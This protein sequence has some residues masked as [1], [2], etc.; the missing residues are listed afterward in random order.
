MNEK[1]DSNAIVD[2]GLVLERNKPFS[3]EIILKADSILYKKYVKRVY[4]HLFYFS[5]VLPSVIYFSM[6]YI[7]DKQ[8]YVSMISIFCF[9][10]IFA[11]LGLI[12]GYYIRKLIISSRLNKITNNKIYVNLSFYNDGLIYESDGVS[13][14]KHYRELKKIDVI[15]N[16]I[17]FYLT[18]RIT[19]SVCKD[20]LD[21]YQ[22]SF[23]DL[24]LDKLND[25]DIL[26]SKK[27]KFYKTNRN[28]GF[29]LMLALLFC[30]ILVFNNAFYLTPLSIVYSFF[31]VRLYLVIYN[32]FVN[33][34]DTSGI[35]LTTVFTFISVFLGY[36][37]FYVNYYSGYFTYSYLY[38]FTFLF[39]IID[40]SA[41]SGYLAD[42][43]FVFS[44]GY[45]LNILYIISHYKK[46]EK[47]KKNN[48]YHISKRDDNALIYIISIIFLAI[49]LFFYNS[50]TILRIDPDEVFRGFTNSTSLSDRYAKEINELK[51]LNE[52]AY[53][54]A[55][56]V[57]DNQEYILN[58]NVSEYYIDCNDTITIY[59][60]LDNGEYQIYYQAYDH[61]LRTN[62]EWSD[63]YEMGGFYNY[64]DL[65]IEFT[66]EGY[67]IIEITNDFDDQI[68]R[69][70]VDGVKRKNNSQSFDT[71]YLQN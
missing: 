47:E 7:S 26:E 71:I 5:L 36:Y 35:I 61:G 54:A 53:N 9:V 24:L 13:I 39:G 65:S 51:D 41:I 37:I 2:S 43:I 4:L 32:R 46:T 6:D 17:F 8:Y 63:W 20:T 1:V 70:F 22:E 10:F 64:I 40:K 56:D 55:L 28:L 42:S 11:T 27:I 14:S 52:E 19:V 49:S 48:N 16:F 44:V 58:H 66:G 29:F 25:T 18:S 59:T 45:T 23:F 30:S 69:I 15:D 34:I 33:Y 21:V 31:M 3:K 57:L 68:I 67:S 50:Y 38:L 62:C 60:N 12:I